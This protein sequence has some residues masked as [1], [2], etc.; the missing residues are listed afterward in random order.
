MREQG[1]MSKPIE[2]LWNGYPGSKMPEPVRTVMR[3]AFF[4]GAAALLG[5]L[6]PPYA[7]DNSLLDAA[8][9]EAVEYLNGVDYD[10]LEKAVTAS[11]VGRF[12]N[13]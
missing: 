4:A 10:G 8:R 13:G 6:G 9:G 2:T 5:E 3:E 12:V 1:A 11:L 7:V